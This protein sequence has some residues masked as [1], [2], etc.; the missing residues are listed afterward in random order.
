MKKFLVSI[1]CVASLGVL[2]FVG[3]DVFKSES[4]LDAISPAELMWVKC[5]VCNAD[6]EMNARA[7]YQFQEA[8]K[9]KMAIQPMKCDKCGKDAVYK[10]VKC[11]KCGYIFLEGSVPGTFTDA[12]PKCSFSKIRSLRSGATN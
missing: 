3:Y 11:E 6:Y 9:Q 5:R 7:Y 12:C 10:A 2:G 8:N 1:L 4:G